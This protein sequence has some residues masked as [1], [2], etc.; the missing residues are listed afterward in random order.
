MGFL[1]KVVKTVTSPLKLVGGMLGMGGGGD[2]G[3][4]GGP[5]YQGG[6]FRQLP[7]DWRNQRMGIDWGT[8]NRPASQRQGYMP[9]SQ[10]MQ[11]R[12]QQRYPERLESDGAFQIGG[13][14]NFYR[15]QQA[16]P[17]LMMGQQMP[18]SLGNVFPAARYVGRGGGFS[19]MM[20]PQP[21]QRGVFPMS[22]M[23]R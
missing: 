23:F 13:N 4:G 7:Q 17:Q 10:L 22:S 16:Q 3:G 6:N 1:K 8:F 2:G 15:Q 14:A 21:P 18:Q 20:A 9:L 5:Q 19:P 11:G 12:G